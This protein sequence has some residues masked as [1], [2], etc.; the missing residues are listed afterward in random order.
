M[1]LCNI[2]VIFPAGNQAAAQHELFAD[3]ATRVVGEIKSADLDN[4]APMA[5]L[6]LLRKLKGE[7]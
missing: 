5:A 6:D 7:L 2:K 4:L 1:L 3:P